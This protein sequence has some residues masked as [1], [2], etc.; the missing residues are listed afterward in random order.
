MHEMLKTSSGWQEK[1]ILKQVQDDTQEAGRHDSLQIPQKFCRFPDTQK[2]PA[3]NRSFKVVGP[4]WL[5]QATR[6]LWAARSDQ[7]S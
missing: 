5:E 3:L 4:A 6:P 1:E 7:L 2:A